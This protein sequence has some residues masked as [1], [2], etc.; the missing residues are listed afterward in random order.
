MDS[1]LNAIK[2]Y[3]EIRNRAWISLNVDGFLQQVC[4]SRNVKWYKYVH[5]LIE[6][7]HRALRLQGKRLLRVHTMT[8]IRDAKEVS[9][10]KIQAY[11]DETIYWVYQDGTQ[12][13]VES[14]VFVHYQEWTYQHGAWLLVA[15]KE[16]SEK[17]KYIV[18][19]VEAVDLSSN[20]L[21]K[22][23]AS[24]APVDE[25]R[26]E[27][28]KAIRYAEL[29]WNEYN[30]IFP[31]LNDDCTNFI[32]QCLFNGR[33]AMTK[34]ANRTI[35][36]WYQ[37]E[38]PFSSEPWSNSWTLSSLL[39]HYLTHHVGAVR[40][41]AAKELK[42]GDVI[43]YDWDGTGRFH[44]S[45]IVTDFDEYGDPVVNAHSDASYHRPYTYFDSRAWS[46]RTKYAYIHIP[47]WFPT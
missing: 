12:F 25:L 33:L 16:S 31:A 43:F 11:V 9:R 40:L 4:P 15:D 23:L 13:A 19:E 27:R 6:R 17:E 29:W 10:L 14:R 20:R 26:Y 3:F 28:V 2:S 41:S 24:D 35:G 22:L 32:S 45:A 42:M 18:T 36:W 8:R 46:G 38:H 30:P 1:W 34:S 21:E 39:F 7:K 44:H 47:D 37:F 5:R